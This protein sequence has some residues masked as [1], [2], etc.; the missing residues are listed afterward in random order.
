VIIVGSPEAARAWSD[1]LT[2]DTRKVDD[3]VII[4]GGGAGVAIARVLIAEGIDVTLIEA[5]PGRAHEV[6]ELLPTVRVLNAKRLDDEFLQRER[7]G[8]TRLGVLALDDDAANL[9]KGVLL[10]RAGVAMTIAAVQDAHAI[11]I[12]VAAG[13]DT[14]ISPRS[15]VAEEIVRFAHDPRT[16]QVTMLEG[17]RFEILDVTCR[18]ESPLVGKP[19]RE[20]PMTGTFVGAIVRNGTAIIPHGDDVLQPG[21]RA[22]LFTE[23]KRATEVEEAL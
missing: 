16:Q 11:D 13:I 23:S 5:D 15:L 18:S 22:I 4:G 6:A 9:Y 14:A 7:L 17:D 19:L 10:K 1:L 2:S 21:D 12:L 3:A 8:H 20:L